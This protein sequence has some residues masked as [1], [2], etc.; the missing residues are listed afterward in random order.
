M[1]GEEC[2]VIYGRPPNWGSN[3]PGHFHTRILGPASRYWRTSRT[4]S[5]LCFS[6]KIGSAGYGLVH[7]YRFSAIRQSGL[8]TFRPHSTGFGIQKIRHSSASALRSKFRS[9][10]GSFGI[11]APILSIHYTRWIRTQT[12]NLKSSN[13]T[14]PLVISKTQL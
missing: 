12:I 4:E 3:W 6:I 10:F 8:S 11:L 9:A 5:Q 2:G 7:R 14:V 13:V 1:Q